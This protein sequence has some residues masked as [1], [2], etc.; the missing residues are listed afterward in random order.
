[1][2]V[3]H[4]GTVGARSVMLCACG[5][6]HRICRAVN[7]RTLLWV[8]ECGRLGVQPVDFASRIFPKREVLRDRLAVAE[9]PLPR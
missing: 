7:E 4:F 5:E 2:G 8:V 1:M 3:R 6:R 9:L